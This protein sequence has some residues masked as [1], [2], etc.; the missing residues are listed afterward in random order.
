MKNWRCCWVAST[1]PKRGAGHGTEK[2]FST[3][4]SPHKIPHQDSCGLK[5]F[6]L[7]LFLQVSPQP[8][9]PK[10]SDAERIHQLEQQLAWAEMKIRVLEERL[11]LQRIHKYGPTSEKLS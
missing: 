9:T 2:S 10:L 7:Y 4:R 5:H 8:S 11:R 1:W 3:S 6:S